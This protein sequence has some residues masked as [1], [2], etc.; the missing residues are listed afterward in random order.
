MGGRGRRK[1]GRSF[2]EREERRRVQYAL[3]APDVAAAAD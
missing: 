3:V 1:R 2:E